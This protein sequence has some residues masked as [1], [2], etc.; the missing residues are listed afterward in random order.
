MLKLKFQ[1]TGVDCEGFRRAFFSW[2]IPFFLLFFF[3]VWGLGLES[4]M[5]FWV[6]KRGVGNDDTG[7]AH[8]AGYTDTVTNCRSNGCTSGSADGCFDDGRSNDGHPSNDIDCGTVVSARCND[9][10]NRCRCSM[11]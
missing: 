1:T 10:T 2:F 5:L 7:P 4:F 11:S 6:V 3:P 8:R 9:G